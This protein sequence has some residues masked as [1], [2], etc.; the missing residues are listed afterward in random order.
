LSTTSLLAVPNVS[1]G[2]DPHR[3]AAIAAAFGQHQATVLDIHSDPDHN[4]TVYTLHGQPGSLAHALEAGAKAAIDL[5]DLNHHEGIH[6]RVGVL[7]VAP[8][9]YRDD[10]ARGAA[11][12]EA[13][14][15]ADLLAE[16]LNLPVFLYGALSYRNHTRAAIRRGGPPGLQQ[17][18]D[19]G[20]QTPDY[21]PHKLHPTAGA[22]LVAARPPLIAFNVELEPPATE[23]EAKRIA[24]EL[25]ESGPNGLPT[26]RALG[27]HLRQR[28]RA[29]ITTNIED[30]T[31][32]TPAD[33][34]A[35]IAEL[36]GTPSRAEIVG[37]PPEAAMR[38]FPEQVPLDNHR[39]LEQALRSHNLE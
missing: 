12:A 19:A 18:I 16:E 39:T 9:V 29:Q 14:V 1:E 10:A 5:I 27:V 23:Q 22:T 37:L 17:R 31:K 2:R 30:H 25:R 36:G 13:L 24:A 35:A 20:E 34:I 28:R 7:D 8:I 32:T 26:L 21:G 6:P 3:I 4:R 38:D 15:L 11:A 33:V